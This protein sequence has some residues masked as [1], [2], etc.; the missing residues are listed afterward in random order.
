[1]RNT[2]T[3]SACDLLQSA[4]DS[5]S[6]AVDC[7]LQWAVD[8]IVGDISDFLNDPQLAPTGKLG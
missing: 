6:S 5:L 3:S 2:I 8:D 7:G 1:M 4:V